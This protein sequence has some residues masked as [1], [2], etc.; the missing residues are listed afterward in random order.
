M[1]YNFYFD[2]SFHTRKITRASLEDTEYF[3]SYISVGIGIKKYM[4]HKILKKYEIIEAKYKMVYSKDE[5]KSDIISKKHY[6]YGIAT[7]NKKEV[8]LYT[9][10]FDFMQKNKIVYYISICDKV[11]YLLNQCEY[12][13]PNFMNKRAIIYS[14]TKLIN[15]YRPQ[16]VI[17]DILNKDKKIITDIKKFFVKQLKE[18]GNIKLKEQENDAMEFILKYI[19]KIDAS[20]IS[21]E[22]NYLFTYIGLKKLQQEINIEKVNVIIDEEGTN[23]IYESAKKIGFNSVSQIDSKLSTGI[24]ISDMLCGFIARMMRALYE[25]TKNDITIPYKEQHLFNE[26]WFK[27]SKE[28]FY[29]YKIIAHYFKQYHE[30]FYSSYISIYFDLFSEFIGLIY[31]FDD[32]NNYD[33]YCKKTP[34]EH[35]ELGNNAIKIRVFSDIKKIEQ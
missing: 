5:L 28:Q 12:K 15:V 26:N 10:F 20:N 34:G 7:F 27:V 4:T 23:K 21:Y 35:C 14:I 31:Y 25:D 30:V 24:R 17:S 16:S 22:F 3:N 6:K 1:E 9:D 18:N 19:D 32:Y 2:E 13:M 29:L 11:E 8:E 33:D